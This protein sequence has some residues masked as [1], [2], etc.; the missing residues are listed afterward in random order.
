MR[1]EINE[2]EEIVSKQALLEKQYEN[3]E[4]KL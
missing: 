2:L 3:Q 4:N 1:E